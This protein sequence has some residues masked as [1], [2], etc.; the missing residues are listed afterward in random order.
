MNTPVK[1][2]LLL[3]ATTDHA[4]RKSDH[5]LEQPQVNFWL[6][7][8]ASLALSAIVREGGRLM[9]SDII[10]TFALVIFWHG[11]QNPIRSKSCIADP[12]FRLGDLIEVDPSGTSISFK[13]EN[14][15]LVEN[16]SWSHTQLVSLSNNRLVHWPNQSLN[17]SQI[18]NWSWLP[19]T[20]RIVFRVPVKICDGRLLLEQFQ[21]KIEQYAKDHPKEWCAV[22]T[23]LDAPVT[24][25][26]EYIE[27]RVEIR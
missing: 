13:K 8:A 9:L 18:I 16:I 6:Y 10:L 26:K 7:I 12:R 21:E 5:D 22:D 15:W 27:Y 25:E 4:S 1:V 2:D 17:K 14:T 24:V 3:Q 11:H 23:P 19:A 20:V